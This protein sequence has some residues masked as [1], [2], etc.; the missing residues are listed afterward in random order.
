LKKAHNPDT[1]NKFE[2]FKDTFAN[3]KNAA[4]CEISNFLKSTDNNTED[5]IEINN[6]KVKIK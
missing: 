6:N 3:N 5:L 4:D 1:I 2:K